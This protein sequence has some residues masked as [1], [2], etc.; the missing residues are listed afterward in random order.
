[1]TRRTL[2]GKNPAGWVPEQKITVEE[3]LRAY[4]VDAAYA[5]FDESRKGALAPGRLADLVMLERNIFEI[6][7][8]EIGDV[9]VALTVAGGKA[10]YR[11]PPT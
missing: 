2:D 9:K 4:T 6:P 5:S 1:V 7:A 10:V 8:E 11:R 3:A